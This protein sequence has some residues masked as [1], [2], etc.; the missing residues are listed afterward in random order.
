MKKI[1]VTGGS[2]FIGRH[3]VDSLIKR[4]YKVTILDLVDPKRNDINFVRGSILN[5][6]L[7][8][9]LLKKNKL[10]FHLAAQSDINKTTKT[11]SKTIMVNILGTVVKQNINVPNIK[12]IF[13]QDIVLASGSFFSVFDAISAFLWLSHFFSS[14]G[15]NQY[16]IGEV[17]ARITRLVIFHKQGIF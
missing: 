3:V 11:P 9:S 10:V 2:G 1:L 6:K 13:S 4:N 14:L 16:Q 15:L 17:I 12:P 5:K 7:I 8:K